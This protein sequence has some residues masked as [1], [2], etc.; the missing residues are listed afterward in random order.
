MDYVR[1]ERRPFLLEAMVSRLYG[2]SSASGANFVPE[3]ADCL[4]ALRE[5]ARGAQ[6][7]HA[8]RDGR[9]RAK[10]RRSC[11]RR[12]SACAKSRS[13]RATDIWKHVF[14]ERDVVV[15]GARPPRAGKALNGDARP[16]DPPRAPRRRRAPRRDRHLRRGRR[17]AARRRLHAVAGAEDRVELAARRARHRRHRHR[18]RAGG[19]AARRRDPVL[20]LRVQ[21]DRPPQA[22]RRHL[23]VV[24]RRLE[25]PDGADDAGRQ[26]H[27][28]EHLPLALVRR[29][30]DAH[31]GLEDRDAEQPARRLR[32]DALGHRRSEPG[33]VPRAEGAAAREG[34]PG[35][36]HP[37]RARRRA[38]ARAR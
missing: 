3:E 38:H 15:E 12:A 19:A 29:A 37:R 17:A 36:A 26:R 33:D 30:G 18:P 35:R 31:P 9:A 7:P 11:S 23:L 8:R 2:H 6:D 24:G 20:R 5:E 34:G 10:T 21:H 25:L 13:R 1:T 27:P 32:P 16:G 22:R 14:A 28:R 4:R